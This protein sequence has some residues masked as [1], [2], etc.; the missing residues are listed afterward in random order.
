MNGNI[1]SLIWVYFGIQAVGCVLGLFVNE[2]FNR[3]NL[4]AEICR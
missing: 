1:A 3:L 4:D 2:Q